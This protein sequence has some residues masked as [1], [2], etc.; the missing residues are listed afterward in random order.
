MT[1]E[2][3][4]HRE[5]VRLDVL[6]H[7]MSDIGHPGARTHPLNRLVQRLLGDFQQ[8]LPLRR[9]RIAHCNRDRRISVIAVQHHAA[10]DRNDVARFQH[11]LF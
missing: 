2:V 1:N 7:G 8:S 4:H 5:P 11:P 10:V 9:N 3:A 6:L